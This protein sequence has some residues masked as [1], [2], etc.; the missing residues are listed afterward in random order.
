MHR[1]IIWPAVSG[2]P[3]HSLPDLV[4]AALDGSGPALLAQ[5]V[6]PSDAPAATTAAPAGVPDDVALVVGTSGSTGLPRR[7]ML[8][9]AA[10]R[11][12]AAASAER[13]GGQ[14]SWL[15]ALPTTHVAGMQVVVR[16]VLAGTTPTVLEGPFRAAAFVEAVGRMPARTAAPGG[17]RFTSL[18]PT[19]LHRLLEPGPDAP[20]A[21]EA[22]RS[23]DAILVG[24]A[25]LAPELA[26]RA[27]AAGVRVVTTYGMSETCGGCVYDGIPLTGVR[28]RT[29]AEGHV[30]VS[31]RV[32][33]IGYLDDDI[34]DAQS[35]T[36]IHGGRW[37][38]TQDL[39]TLELSED[40]SFLTLT[41]HG[42]SDDVI[43]TGGEK[44]VAGAVEAALTGWQGLGEVAVV[45]VP[46]DEWG[47]AVVAVA[48]LS[49]GASA[50]TLDDV[51]AHVRAAVAPPAAP[52]A[53]EIVDAVPTLGIG[54][55]D[56]DAVRDLVLG[57]RP[58]TVTPLPT[59][60][61]GDA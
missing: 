23:F 13:L 33:S 60:D 55:P 1:P 24:G 4:R 10:L 44:V 21:L 40:T 61:F 12:S 50:P 16:S 27:A 5:P 54:K 57:R 31:G 19:Q 41:V 2:I 47:T 46:D 17:G 7:V 35:Y 8:T 3:D 48:T 28:I 20:A 36:T 6:P 38:R 37:L 51:R 22:L 9:A 43:V 49:P 56:R 32:L 18:V 29:S 39:G 45:G 59:Q 30:L 25:A 26:A 42:R 11:A 15:L 14:G 53:L 52:R 58:G 34:A